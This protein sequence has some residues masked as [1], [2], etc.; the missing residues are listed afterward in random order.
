MHVVE[1]LTEITRNAA[2]SL[3]KNMGN[4]KFWKSTLRYK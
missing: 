3:L 4:K 2:Y 1:D